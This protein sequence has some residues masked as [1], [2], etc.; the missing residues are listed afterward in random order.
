MGLLHDR[1]DR[2]EIE[3]LVIGQPW[4]EHPR[5]GKD[6][7]ALMWL[8]RSFG[9]IF[10]E[11][12]DQF[13]NMRDV[14]VGSTDEW[15]AA[16]RDVPEA[17]V[18]KAIASLLSEPTKKDWGGESDDHFSGNVS[19][20]G[21]RRTAAFLLEGPSVFRELTLDGRGVVACLCGD[22]G[23]TWRELMIIRGHAWIGVKTMVLMSALLVTVAC[24]D[25]DGPTLPTAPSP[26]P[27]VASSGS[28]QLSL[29]G[30]ESLGAGF[31]YEGWLL[32]D[33]N[34]V[35]TGTF[36]VG[37][38]GSL[39]TSMFSVDQAALQAATKF[40][41][42]IEPSP[43]SSPMPAATKYLAGDFVGNN[44]S[45][46]VGDAA[47][48]GNDFQSASGG[49]ILATPS[50]NAVADD[51]ASGIWWLDP[52]SHSASL[53]L[54]A[55]PAGWMYEGWVVGPDGP[56]T[57]GRFTEATGADSDGG[58]PGAGPDGTPA[59][60]GQEFI[61]PPVSLIGYRAVISIEPEPDDSPGPFTLKPLVDMD[62]ED[63][64]AMVLQD[65]ANNAAS[66]PTGMA[67]R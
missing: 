37:A 15:M 42:T 3:P 25:D 51:Y 17:V 2:F 57:T 34:P 49:F 58:G 46:S 59:V 20:R 41:L 55:L 60:P 9:E 56:V 29:A 43:D 23:N 53:M 65:M 33:G 66:F 12:I 39:S 67:T 30:L 45:L 26:I 27:P 61:T 35:S 4:F 18:K 10:P 11:D 19:V 52:A 50:T 62:I 22:V 24:G 54:P 48:L 47:T 38:D 7:P 36:S 40:I 32:V 8:G 6:A 64:G 13:S 28:L 5:N 1:D 14:E 16:M 44:A 31:V 63:V 21:H